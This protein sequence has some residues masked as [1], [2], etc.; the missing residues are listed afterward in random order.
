MIAEFDPTMQEHIR[1]IKTGEIHDH[2]LGHNIQNELILML[3]LEIKKSIVNKVK[4]AKY[5]SVILDCTADVS[6]QEQ[7]SLI[8]RCVDISTNLVKIEEYFLG[9]LQVDNTTG[10]GLLMN[11]GQGYDNGSN[12]KG[13]N[14]GV[15]K[16]L[17]DINPRAFYTPC[18]CH[19]LNLVLCDMANSCRKAISFFGVGQRVYSLFSSSPKR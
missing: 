9:F 2:Y 5:F 15:Q 16:R 3:A 8:L 19:S 7:M 6:H 17:L 1:R 10:K 4:E 11:L 13:K 12:M 18:G 14:Q